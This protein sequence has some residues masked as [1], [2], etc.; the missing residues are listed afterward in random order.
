MASKPSKSAK[1]GG[2]PSLKDDAAQS[3]LPFEPVSTKK[4]VPK[5]AP[6]TSAKGSAVKDKTSSPPRSPA[7]SKTMPKVVSDRMARRM[8]F[9]SGIPSV[10]AMLTFVVSYTL[11][12]HGVNLPNYAVLLVSL[13]FFGLGVLGLSYGVISASWDEGHVGTLLGWSEFRLNLGRIIAS[14]REGRE[15]SNTEDT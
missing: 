12:N 5:K 9:F 6:T 13:G 11:I 4:K 3:G 14:W 2:G 15:L 7:T 10:C 1:T 8:A